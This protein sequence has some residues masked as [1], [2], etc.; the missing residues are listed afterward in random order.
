[1][2]GYKFTDKKQSKMGMV[3][4]FFGALSIGMLGYG[5]NTSFEAD[6]KAGAIVGVLALI[7]FLCSIVGVVLGIKSF[8]DDDVFYLFSWIGTVVNIIIF[9]FC[10]SM[11]LIG[12]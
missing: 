9:V 4:T 10:L 1:M 11:F 3:S 2:K 7:S 5:I 6:G 12:V 8:K